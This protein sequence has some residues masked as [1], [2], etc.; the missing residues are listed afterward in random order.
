MKDAGKTRGVANESVAV[1]SDNP[2]GSDVI[3]FASSTVWGAIAFEGITQTLSSKVMAKK[4]AKI[5]QEI[6]PQVI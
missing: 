5:L 1:K 6:P 4:P 2:T 3:A